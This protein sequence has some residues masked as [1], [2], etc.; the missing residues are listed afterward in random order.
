[1]MKVLE[2]KNFKKISLRLKPGAVPIFAKSRPV[3]FAF[4]DK[5]ERELSTLEENVVIQ[6]VDNNG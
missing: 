3:P 1:M 5:I 6:M 4:K 2:L